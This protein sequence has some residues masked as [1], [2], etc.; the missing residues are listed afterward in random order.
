MP[1]WEVRPESA[2]GER[3]QLV[4]EPGRAFGT[5]HH[6]STT[7]CLTLLEDA[8]AADG[9]RAGRMLDV[10]TGTGV[11]AIAAVLL[12]IPA[13]LAIDVDP[14][15]IASARLNAEKNGCADRIALELEGPE[16]LAPGERFSLV[17][18]NLLSHTHRALVAQYARLVAPGGALILG[19][20]LAD[21]RRSV[22]D[23]LGAAGFGVAIRLVIDDWASLLL[24]APAPS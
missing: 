2:S 23:A 12:G 8:P 7:G 1:P 3:V 24:R 17:T 13:A 19:G 18:A 10:G 16:T 15:A 11:L 9:T 4:I 6:A 14:D 5:G 21:E 22:C 20:I